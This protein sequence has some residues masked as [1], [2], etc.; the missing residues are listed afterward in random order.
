MELSSNKNSGI[1]FDS[2]KGKKHHFEKQTGFSINAKADRIT[3]TRAQELKADY[4][5]VVVHDFGDDYHLSEEEKAEKFQ[6]Y[7]AFKKVRRCKRKYRKLPEYVTAFRLCLDCLDIIANENGLYPPAKFKM[8]V[9]EGLI[10]VFGLH[11]PK[12]VGRDRK[13]IN[14]DYV[15]SVIA[16]RTISPS[17][18][19][20]ADSDFDID[21][22][23]DLEEYRKIIFGEQ[24]DLVFNNDDFI[25]ASLRPD[26][27]DKRF[28]IKPYSASKQKELLEAIPALPLAVRDMKRQIDR[29]ADLSN[30][31]HEIGESDFEYI[32][33][34]DRDRGF[35]SDMPQF[36]GDIMD[37]D[38]Y[39]KYLYELDEYMNEKVKVS[40]YGKNK[41]PDEIRMIQIKDMLEDAG[42][43]VRALY[44][45]SSYEKKEKKKI[46]EDK[47][48][49]KKLKKKL[50]EI[51]KRRD[52]KKGKDKDTEIKKKSKGKKK[53]DKKSKKDEYK[54][55]VMDYFDDALLSNIPDEED[56]EDF[57]Q[58]QKD[59]IDFTSDN[60]F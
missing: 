3:E 51:Q 27:V 29:H 16:D 17:V 45:S 52:K 8:M 25:L 48:K 26:D 44:K 46:K 18:F 31:T 5:Q 33:R 4:E 2:N 6:Y 49:E 39:N 42:W 1:S 15:A 13:T 23:E 19:D 36:N 20:K 24:Y 37:T 58:Y 57:K 53:K 32:E 12:Y 22:I 55:E 14:W 59:M 34:I 50:I 35:V 41:T 28:E 56:Y 38:A 21:D 9:A 30:F 43:N 54:K 47:K 7:E 40:Y 10:N 11:F 60:I